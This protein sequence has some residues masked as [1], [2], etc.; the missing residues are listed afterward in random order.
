MAE[1]KLCAVE[2]CGKRA[3]S[4]GWC[5]AHYSRWFRH[6]DPLAGKYPVKGCSVHG[7]R[8]PHVSHGYCSRHLSKFR[9]YGDPLAGRSLAD[10][11]K[12]CSVSECEGKVD[13]HGLCRKHLRRM[14]R[15]GSPTGGAAYYIG[16]QEKW[17]REASLIETD[18]CILWPFAI[19]PNG[20]GASSSRPNRGAHRVMCEMVHGKAPTAGH[21]VAHSCNVRA[22]VNPRHLRWA[23][24][25]ENMLDKIKHGTVKRGTKNPQAKL[26][27]DNVLRIRRMKGRVI[28][29]EVAEMFG[30]SI[31]TVHSIWRGET[32]GWLEGPSQQ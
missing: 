13:S 18:E 20:Y 22:C 25:S 21:E 26:S 12:V 28:L 16:D 32:W 11:P 9:K 2:G 17:L 1:I 10:F 30:V 14:Q 27:E 3:T 31:T 6:G 19:N 15:Y 29:R 4:R 8:S 5:G 24:K 23:T 7:C